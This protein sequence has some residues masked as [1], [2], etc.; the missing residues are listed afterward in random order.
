MYNTRNADHPSLCIQ[1][2]KEGERTVNSV[3]V[4]GGVW[5]VEALV[6]LQIPSPLTQNASR[7]PSSSIS[8]QESD[9]QPCREVSLSAL[10]FEG[11]CHRAVSHDRS[12]SLQLRISKMPT[13]SKYQQP[14]YQG[15]L[16]LVESCQMRKGM[17]MLLLSRRK[18]LR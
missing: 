2:M 3:C 12:V 7:I 8:Y 13:K 6:N 10:R 15:T 14:S 5:K 1:G 11:L 4:V 9:Y 16:C 18:C 17:I